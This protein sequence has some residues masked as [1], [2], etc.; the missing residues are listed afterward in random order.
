MV[1]CGQNDQPSEVKIIFKIDQRVFGP[2]YFLRPPPIRSLETACSPEST[3]GPMCLDLGAD[4]DFS[5]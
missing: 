4:L 3:C 5:C 2:T 1:H